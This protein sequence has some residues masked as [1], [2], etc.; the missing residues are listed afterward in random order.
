MYWAMQCPSLKLLGSF[1]FETILK[2]PIISLLISSVKL[3][4]QVGQV[5][6][7]WLLRFEWLRSWEFAELGLEILILILSKSILIL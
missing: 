7:F 1:Q 4:K 2:Y 3:V 6:K 5:G